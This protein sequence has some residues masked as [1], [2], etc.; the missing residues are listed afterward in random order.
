M[1]RLILIGIIVPKG[2]CWRLTIGATEQ[3]PENITFIG[4]MAV[5]KNDD[6]K[7]LIAFRASRIGFNENGNYLIN[8]G[9]EATGNK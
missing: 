7:D 9:L 6:E 5:E 1:D 2:E 8:P 4:D 3:N